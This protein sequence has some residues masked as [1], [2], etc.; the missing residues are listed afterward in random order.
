MVEK[1]QYRS[2]PARRC[3]WHSARCTASTVQQLDDRP[4]S[5]AM[6]S[7]RRRSHSL[8][9]R[10]KRRTSGLPCS[11]LFSMVR[12]LRVCSWSTQMSHDRPCFAESDTS[13]EAPAFSPPAC[14]MRRMDT[15]GASSSSASVSSSRPMSSRRSWMDSQREALPPGVR[16]AR[17]R[18]DC[19]TSPPHD[20]LPTTCSSQPRRGESSGAAL[21]AASTRWWRKSR[22]G[23]MLLT[24][25]SISSETCSV[26]SKKTCFATNSLFP[27]SFGHCIVAAGAYGGP[28]PAPCPGWDGAARRAFGSCW[29]SSWAWGRSC[30]CARQAPLRGR[31]SFCCCC[32]CW[33]CSA[34]AP[35]CGLPAQAAW[36]CSCS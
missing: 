27:P 1:N 17:S 31:C 6:G 29:P 8:T 26:A 19:G 4:P 21:R 34:S 14:R 33:A 20:A 25:F 13:G 30:C 16:S 11:V 12:C 9:R 18:S 3:G 10:T 32:C 23:C 24:S 36:S 5:P 15:R 22:L 7:P 35:T 28:A 2:S